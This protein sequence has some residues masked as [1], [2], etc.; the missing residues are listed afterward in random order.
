M[1]TNPQPEIIA[2]LKIIQS[3]VEECFWGQIT[4]KFKDGEPIAVQQEKQ[5]K[6]RQ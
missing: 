2:L 6:L 3:L 5:I 1:K 4:I